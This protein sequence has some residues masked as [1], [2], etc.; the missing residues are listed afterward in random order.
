[1]VARNIVVQMLV[2]INPFEQSL[3]TI[4][5]ILNEHTPYCNASSRY[6]DNLIMELTCQSF[7]AFSILLEFLVLDSWL[8]VKRK[9]H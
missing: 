1:M 6:L 5:E 2:I 7:V 9:K 8:D 4:I 3:L